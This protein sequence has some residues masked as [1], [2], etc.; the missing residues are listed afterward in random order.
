MQTE[1]KWDNRERWESWWGL[2]E[3]VILLKKG[4]ADSTEGHVVTTA[5][6]CSAEARRMT[7]SSRDSAEA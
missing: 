2:E 5:E 1:C 7:A 6:L 3:G 4:R